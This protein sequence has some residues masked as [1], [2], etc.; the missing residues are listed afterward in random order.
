[1]TKQYALILV[2]KGYL[3]I[4]TQMTFSPKLMEDRQTS[5]VETEAPMAGGLRRVPS[6]DEDGI[7]NSC[8]RHIKKMAFMSR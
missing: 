8:A 1:M 4:K 3:S 7:I 5:W 6:G 2:S